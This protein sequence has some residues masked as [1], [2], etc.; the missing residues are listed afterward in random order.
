MAQPAYKCFIDS[1]S[2]RWKLQWVASQ[3]YPIDSNN[4]SKATESAPPLSATN[5][6]SFR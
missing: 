5:T 6:L 4:R 1:L 3:V 2:R